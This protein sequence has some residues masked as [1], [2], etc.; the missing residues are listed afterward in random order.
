M[1]YILYINLK[2]KGQIFRKVNCIE[3]K[4]LANMHAICI[5]IIDY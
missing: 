1:Y 4:L 3:Q 2:W 5:F